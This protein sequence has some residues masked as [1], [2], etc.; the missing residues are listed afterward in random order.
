MTVHAGYTYKGELNEPV[1]CVLTR[2]HPKQ[3]E[4]NL[5]LTCCVQLD[6]SGSFLPPLPSLHTYKN[7]R[8]SSKAKLARP[9]LRRGLGISK[10]YS[11]PQIHGSSIP[12]ASSSTIYDAGGSHNTKVVANGNYLLQPV[13]LLLFPIFLMGVVC[14][15]NSTKPPLQ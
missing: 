8:R 5:S 7:K 6:P 10:M 1:N 9:R 3:H 13:S 14:G 4:P 15:T 12:H 2:A 11:P